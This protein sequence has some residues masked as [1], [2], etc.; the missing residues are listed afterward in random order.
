MIDACRFKKNTI[1]QI[2]YMAKEFVLH[3]TLHYIY[4]IKMNYL[5]FLSFC[6]YIIIYVFYYLD[7]GMKGR[8]K[9]KKNR[10]Q[11]NLLQ[12]KRNPTENQKKKCFKFFM[13]VWM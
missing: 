6:I 2:R 1:T 5:H 9:K 4:K 13:L 11:L 8:M 12:I 7:S 3:Y 10:P